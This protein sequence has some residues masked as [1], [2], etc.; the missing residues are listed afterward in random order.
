MIPETQASREGP[1]GE[2]AADQPQMIFRGQGTVARRGCT[3]NLW[4]AAA[5]ERRRLACVRAG[6][7]RSHQAPKICRTPARRC[8]EPGTFF[9][10][11]LRWSW[12]NLGGELEDVANGGDHAEA[13][14]GM[15]AASGDV[16]LTISAGAARTLTPAQREAGVDGLEVP[17]A[18]AKGG[19]RWCRT[20]WLP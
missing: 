3:T 12:T 13:A 19:S 8:G 14:G 15:N 6:R 20:R 7:P 2:N 5:W 9:R 18:T 1:A 11:T 16:R 4:S 17:S 10:V